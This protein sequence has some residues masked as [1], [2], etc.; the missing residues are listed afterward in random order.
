VVVPTLGLALGAPVMSFSNGESTT[1]VEGYADVIE[2][3][4][5]NLIEE[6]IIDQ[7]ATGDDEEGEPTVQE[8]IQIETIY[9]T[10]DEADSTEF[11]LGVVIIIVLIMTT[12]VIVLLCICIYRTFSSQRNA[13]LHK[14]IR[15][16]VGSGG[17][18]QIT[19]GGDQYDE[20]GRLQTVDIKQQYVPGRKEVDRLSFVADVMPSHKRESSQ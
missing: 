2:Q 1:I 5:E 8:V 19:A 9:V 6:W 13:K 14:K 12:I 17:V 3:E 7:I 4:N 11:A 15:E 16:K 10:K 18:V 20:F